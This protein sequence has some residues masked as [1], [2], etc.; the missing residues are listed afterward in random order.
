MPKLHKATCD[1]YFIIKC[2]LKLNVEAKTAS[3]NLSKLYYYL[4][5]SI[6]IFCTLFTV[7][8]SMVFCK[9]FV[10]ECFVPSIRLLL[11]TRAY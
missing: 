10:L 1:N 3:T 6:R 4:H 7:L 11:K 5:I 8:Y 9:R 2:L